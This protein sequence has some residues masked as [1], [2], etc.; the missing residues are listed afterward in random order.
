[1]DR[2]FLQPRSSAASRLLRLAFLALPLAIAG[3]GGGGNDAV[4][5][6]KLRGLNVHLVDSSSAPPA[7]VDGT[8]VIFAPRLN[9]L[10]LLSYWL[11]PSMS[12]MTH[13][14]ESMMACLDGTARP[15][16]SNWTPFFRQTVWIDDDGDCPVGVSC[17]W[18]SSAVIMLDQTEIASK[19]RAPEF[20][21]SLF[22]HELYHAVAGYYHP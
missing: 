12:V 1:M 13:I 6:S 17:Y 2:L 4:V 19:S 14:G 21:A 7:L 10:D 9:A 20:V 15:Y 5:D 22:G 16:V 3:C 18:P 11:N 8:C